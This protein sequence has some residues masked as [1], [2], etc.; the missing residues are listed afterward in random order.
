MNKKLF[1]LSLVALCSFSLTSCSKKNNTSSKI[2]STYCENIGP[3]YRVYFYT[4]GGSEVETKE[5]AKNGLLNK[6]NDP[7]Y[8]GK[9]FLGWYTNKACTGSAFDFSTPITDNMVLYAKWGG[10]SS[11]VVNQY[12]Q[13]WLTKSEENHLYIH[14]LRFNNEPSEYSDWDIWAWPKSKDGTNF[15]F[16]T[17]NGTI[18]VDELGGAYCDIDLTKTYSQAGWLNG[19]YVPGY[20][21]SFMTNGELT[22]DVG[23]QI[24]KKST[25]ENKDSYW[26][27]DGDDNMVTLSKAKWS[28][29]SY[30]IFC[31]QN[32]VPNFTYQFSSEQT[33][34]PYDNDDG[35]NV[36]ISNVNSSKSDNYSVS[37]TSKDFLNNVGVGY[38]IMVASF[39]D[40]DG[41]GMGD[42]LGI[43]NKLDYLK[44]TLHVNTLWL[45]PVQLS[46]SYHGYDT[47]DYKIVDPKFGSKA[48]KNNVNGE[49]T[50]ESAMKDYQDLL[51]KAKEKG[52]RVIM[53]L[54]VNHTS[55]KN[56]WFIESS[57]LNPDY[58]SFYQWKKYDEVKTNKNW[59]QYS[60]TDYAYYGKFASSMP[61][62]NYDYQGTR[63]AM[64]DVAKFWLEKGVSGF[65]IDAVK[66]V[67]MEDEVTHGSSDKIIEDNDSSKGISYSSN[68]TKNLNF[69]RE[70]N[71]RVKQINKDA[72]VLGENFDGNAVNNVA[73]Y[74]EGLDSL[75]DFYLYYKLSNIAMTDSGDT[76]SLGARAKAISNDTGEW[77]VPGIIKKYNS[78]RGDQ[79]IDSPFTSNHDTSRV[80]NMMI[81]KATNADDQSAVN[82]TDSNY[83]VAIERAKCYATVMTMLPGITWI[84]YGDELGMTSNFA[85]GED[86]NSPHVDRWYRQPYKFNNN[87]SATKDG[88]GV[89]QTGFSFTGGAGFEIGYDS[90]NKTK[91]VSAE[92]QLKDEN[93]MLSYYSKLTQLKSTSNAFIS[94]SYKGISDS[95]TVF[96]FQRTGSDG[97][98]NVYVNFGT[99]KVNVKVEGNVL[100]STGTVTSSTLAP[101]SAVITKVK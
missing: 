71:A 79:A 89:Y 73:P 9:Q 77:C 11:D 63:D 59:H 96:A 67:Y 7:I 8:S 88:D 27:N 62:L 64:V 21:M 24:V 20:T 83:Q 16:A 22:T 74:Y 19:S 40:S 66:H 43:T 39:A 53:D 4:N 37:K 15:D 65:R 34:N 50:G 10:I 1:C 2:D 72:L 32:N 84:Y 38:Q 31:V 56:T 70:F 47:I 35:N 29:G 97:T 26:T 58:R 55:K 86:K 48:S 99:S 91:L 75:F 101:H 82:V 92:D 100:I 57:K 85:S 69:F 41:D 93:S 36:S 87:D 98:Y 94:G 18:Y 52:I 68:L 25:R 23:F 6:P 45:T 81:G 54:V 12:N 5:V 61:E 90:Y 33:D 46:D 51:A 17:E 44:D 60:T 28:N 80:M 76:N 49:V 30:H 13:T 42:I 78:Y 14:Y 3:V 95:D